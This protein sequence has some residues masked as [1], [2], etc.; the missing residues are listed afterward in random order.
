M[1]KLRHRICFSFKGDLRL[2]VSDEQESIS[3]DLT[4]RRFRDY[5]TNTETKEA[6]IRG[7][8]EGLRRSEKIG[9]DMYT[10]F[11]DMVECQEIMNEPT[12]DPLLI[13]N[14]L[15]KLIE[16]NQSITHKSLSDWE[17]KNLVEGGEDIGERGKA[18]EFKTPLSGF[19]IHNSRNS[20]F[21]SR[22]SSEP[23]LTPI[24]H[25]RISDTYN[26]KSDEKIKRA[27]STDRVEQGDRQLL[28]ISKT[29]I[30][31]DLKGTDSG[32]VPF[33]EEELSQ[34]HK[35]NG[36]KSI[37]RLNTP[38]IA[39]KA[40]H[41][42]WPRSKYPSDVGDE[43]R[44][45]S[46]DMWM[47]KVAVKPKQKGHK[48]SSRN[49][50]PKTAVRMEDSL[51]GL[52]SPFNNSSANLQNKHI[53]N[54]GKDSR[55]IVKNNNVI[56]IPFDCFDGWT[57]N[58]GP[59]TA[60][61]NLH[62][63]LSESLHPVESF[64]RLDIQEK[65]DDDISEN[66]DTPK[67]YINKDPCYTSNQNSPF[68]PHETLGSD[69]KTYETNAFKAHGGEAQ[70][71]PLIK[72]IRSQ[73]DLVKL[74]L[75]RSCCESPK[76]NRNIPISKCQSLQN[77]KKFLSDISITKNIDLSEKLAH[78]LKDMRKETIKRAA[79]ISSPLTYQR[80]ALSSRDGNRSETSHH[81]N[82]GLLQRIASDNAKQLNQM[83][84]S[85]PQIF[86]SRAFTPDKL[87]QRTEGVT[88][89]HQLVTDRFLP[90]I[91]GKSILDIQRTK[92]M[93]F[94][95]DVIN[96][97]QHALTPIE[98]PAEHSILKLKKETPL[99]VT[100]TRNSPRNKGH[101]A[102]LCASCGGVKAIKMP[103]NPVKCKNIMSNETV[104]Y[105]DNQAA[106]ESDMITDKH[107]FADETRKHKGKESTGR[108]KSG[109]ERRK[110]SAKHQSKHDPNSSKDTKV[111]IEYKDKD[112]K[113]TC[114]VTVTSS[115]NET[116]ETGVKEND[117]N[118]APTR[119]DEMAMASHETKENKNEEKPRRVDEMAKASHRENMECPV[120][121]ETGIYGSVKKLSNEKEDACS[122]CK[123]K[124]DTPS[125]EAGAQSAYLEY[126]KRREQMRALKQD[127][128]HE[129]MNTFVSDTLIADLASNV[130]KAEGRFLP[131][132]PK[133]RSYDSMKLKHAKK[134]K[135]CPK[136][137]SLMT[138][139]I[140]NGAERATPCDLVVTPCS[141]PVIRRRR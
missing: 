24:D 109:K 140:E 52:E 95:K 42:N 54:T 43:E 111:H 80:S 69:E 35:E 82:N 3:D 77:R 26:S 66:I 97:Y 141:L 75:T 85:L 125:N 81:A 58:L 72:E 40:Y 13:E 135:L 68:L 55:K 67:V 114:D 38:K 71:K 104:S 103:D 30:H 90:P 33:D 28:N 115:G 53:N 138:K 31:F 92:S 4:D 22:S 36:D 60:N 119:I 127:I 121:K 29:N 102:M 34:Y 88:T 93:D 46:P 63:S 84:L 126:C 1:I 101:T 94:A 79:L 86:A 98:V 51:S 83:H 8:L 18:E 96:E 108:N 7:F 74:R 123:D 41:E 122:P 19:M 133:R 14:S 134:N 129:D 87:G 2:S 39:H 139:P 107:G 48:N 65:N 70:R 56:D 110:N 117:E 12:A 64:D 45:N 78:Q 118:E 61:D 10:K 73:S 57:T 137:K 25:L 5:D 50:T 112:I 44:L 113:L 32:E 49:K 62:L 27:H 11:I 20:E 100:S 23:K 16:N 17:N 124:G 120:M 59:C 130:R 37:P 6:F 21:I 15:S 89:P 131:V 91:S 136:S 47:R 116:D 105:L 132:I 76:S 106:Y 99:I 9:S 128:F